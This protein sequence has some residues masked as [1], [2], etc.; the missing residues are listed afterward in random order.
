MKKLF[1][2]VS[3]LFLM[4]FVPAQ[5]SA[6]E[7]N[8]N[9]PSEQMQKKDHGKMDPAKMAENRAQRMAKEY[10]LTTEQQQQLVT[11]F[12]AEMQNHKGGPRGGFRQMSKEQRDSMQTAMKAEKEK[13]DSSLKKILTS[14]QYAKYVKDQKA[15]MEKM[16]EQRQGGQE[17]NKPENEKPSDE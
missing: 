15:R 9:Q 14:D 16:R 17:G 8:E 1:V 13:F 4:S 5:M 7:N 6:Q 3:A 10:N 2:M 11:L 12:K